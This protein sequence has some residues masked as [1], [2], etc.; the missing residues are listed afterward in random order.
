MRVE[1]RKLQ[2]RWDV[3]QFLAAS[4]VKGEQLVEF[5]RLIHAQV[6]GGSVDRFLGAEAAG[7][8]DGDAGARRE[9][10]QVEARFGNHLVERRAPGDG[11]P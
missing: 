4:R 8:Q 11:Q 10:R 7:S 1:A 5:G 6:G 3:I 9:L 2:P